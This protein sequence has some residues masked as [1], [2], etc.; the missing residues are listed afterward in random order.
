[1]KNV[2]HSQALAGAVK[3]TAASFLVS[4]EPTSREVADQVI[5]DYETEIREMGFD[6]GKAHIYE[7]ASKC[8]KTA[9]STVG[10]GE[11]FALPFD[12]PGVPS[13]ISFPC[14]DVI[15][16]VAIARAT[17]DHLFAYIG[18]LQEQIAADKR[19]LEAV[20][21][22]H[23]RLADVF[24]ANPGINVAAAATLYLSLVPSGR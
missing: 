7:L 17:E 4:T 10:G 13:A 22:L 18:I 9:L 11:Q 21:T 5:A 16:Y 24:A 19:K 1:L 12:L 3:N 14:G 15:R 8:M 2:N 20:Q 6:L 23:D